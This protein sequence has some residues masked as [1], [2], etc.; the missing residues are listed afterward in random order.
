MSQSHYTMYVH[1]R[2]MRSLNPLIHLHAAK[3]WCHPCQFLIAESY[4]QHFWGWHLAPYSSCA[5]FLE[6]L[7][8]WSPDEEGHH[9]RR[10]GLS[11]SYRK[12]QSHGW[13]SLDGTQLG[14]CTGRS[15][16]RIAR[17]W[18]HGKKRGHHH[19]RRKGVSRGY[20]MSQ[21]HSW[22]S[23]GS[24]QL[25]IVQVKAEVVGSPGAGV[26]AR[27]GK[28]FPGSSMNICRYITRDLVCGYW[29]WDLW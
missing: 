14:I 27:R 18:S 15:W 6:V 4:Q 29:W 9:G 11:R 25:G 2:Q 22:N 7:D 3:T 26:M 8:P 24:A 28:W 1:V 21:S 17:S 23:L 19:G 10:K 16:G 5:L 20:R 12:S 13:N